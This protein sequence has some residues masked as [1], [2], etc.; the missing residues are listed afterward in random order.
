MFRADIQGLRALAVISVVAFHANSDLVPGGFVGVDIFF[1]IS[2]FLITRIL[3][4]QLEKGDFSFIEFY[5][6]RMRRIF[7][8]LFTMLIASMIAGYFLL[9]PKG[10]R[11]LG[12]TT[13]ATIF[14]FYNF[15]FIRHTGYFFG[16]LILNL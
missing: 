5:K 14:F 16:S 1:V 10:F 12:E 2:G 8:A 6:R 13:F 3:F 7:P 4:R 9:P 11:E 15:D